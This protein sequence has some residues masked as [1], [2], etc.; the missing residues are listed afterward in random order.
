MD[1]HLVDLLE[2]VST[3]VDTTPC[4][5]AGILMLSNDLKKLANALPDNALVIIKMESSRD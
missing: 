5:V 3:K 4:N 1:A 2:G